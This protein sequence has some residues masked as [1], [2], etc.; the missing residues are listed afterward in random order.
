MNMDKLTALVRNALGEAQNIALRADHQRLCP[1]HL[2]LALLESENTI[3]AVLIDRAGG[4]SM[5]LKDALEKALSQMPSVTGTG[6]GQLTFDT[7]LAKILAQA[8]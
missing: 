5:V 1:E 8:E 4:D 7:S 3:A 6:A 2:L